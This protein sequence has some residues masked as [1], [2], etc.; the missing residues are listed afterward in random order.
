M[1]VVRLDGTKNRRQKAGTVTVLPTNND[2]WG[3]EIR[4][5]MSLVKGDFNG[6]RFYRD[7]YLE[8]KSRGAPIEAATPRKFSWVDLD[9]IKVARAWLE[10]RGDSAKWLAEQLALK[11]VARP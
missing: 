8:L 9:A 4:I 2:V 10:G 1:V 6:A 11:M 5:G 3:V 7:Q